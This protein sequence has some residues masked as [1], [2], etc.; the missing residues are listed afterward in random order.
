MP[1]LP[2]IGRV[3]DPEAQELEPVTIPLI[4]YKPDKEEVEI[5]VKFRAK[6]AP[7]TA[8]DMLTNV[9]AQ[10]NIRYADML[11]YL[12]SCIVPEDRDAVLFEQSTIIE[13][14]RALAEFYDGNKR[15]SKRRPGSQG[16]PSKTK[17]TSR[18]AESSHESTGK[19]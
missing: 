3:D 8:F 11:G 2:A 17:R 6:P 10:G 4:G 13:A 9:D 14:Y 1:E 5:R 18:G 16:G 12:Y 7:G 19:H 15:P